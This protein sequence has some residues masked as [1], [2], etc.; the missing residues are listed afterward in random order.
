MGVG[1]VAGDEA[2][3]RRSAVD[4]GVYDRSQD[5]AEVRVLVLVRDNAGDGLP[6]A[7]QEVPLS[8]SR[9]YATNQEASK[10]G[11]PISTSRA[12]TPVYKSTCESGAPDDSWR[13]RGRAG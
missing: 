9:L 6:L 8:V 5:A 13:R 1:G 3:K 10:F 4:D 12:T 2:A 11:V 7:Q